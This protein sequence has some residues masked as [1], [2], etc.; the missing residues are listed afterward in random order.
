MKSERG[1]GEGRESRLLIRKMAAESSH[2]RKKETFLSFS[3]PKMIFAN[4][5]LLAIMYHRLKIY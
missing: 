1:D 4:L 5:I 2:S 3:L